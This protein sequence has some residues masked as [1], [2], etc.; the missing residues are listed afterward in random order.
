MEKNQS[1]QCNKC[2]NC[3][4]WA[5]SPKT[6]AK[7]KRFYLRREKFGGRL[8]NPTAKLETKHLIY[9]TSPLIRVQ[10]LKIDISE[11]KGSS[12]KY[13]FSLSATITYDPVFTLQKSR[14]FTGI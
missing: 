14:S 3:F 13:E 1:Y 2:R 8:T 10:L 4:T 11:E 9:T 5:T 12:S 7:E 6:T